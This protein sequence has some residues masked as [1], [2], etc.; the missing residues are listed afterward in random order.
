METEFPENVHEWTC[1]DVQRW[2]DM[3]MLGQYKLAGGTL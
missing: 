3:L 1:A 2:L